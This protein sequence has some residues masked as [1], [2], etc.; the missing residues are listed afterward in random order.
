ML[1]AQ[2]GADGPAAPV[3]ALVAALMEA[4]VFVP[5]KDAGAVAG[6]PHETDAEP[7]MLNDEH[8]EPVLALFTSRERAQTF[9]KDFPGFAGG[10]LTDL[11]GIMQ[12]WGV[13]YA[14]ALNPGVS[15]GVDLP[16]AMVQQFGR[17]LLAEATADMSTPQ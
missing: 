4:Q 3:A 15:V 16:R 5:V 17:V 2:D 11:K 6:F 12:R 8:G 1:A 9:V 10:L 13:D 14:I 7:L